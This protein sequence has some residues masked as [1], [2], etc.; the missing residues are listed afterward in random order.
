MSAPT[1]TASHENPPIV[2][3]SLCGV[4][5]TTPGVSVTVTFHLGDHQAALWAL[6]TAITDVCRQIADAA[7]GTSK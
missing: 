7:E 3:D 2:T 5:R 6:D 4:V 1:V